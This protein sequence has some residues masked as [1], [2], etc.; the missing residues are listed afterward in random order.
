[1]LAVYAQMAERARDLAASIRAGG[2]SHRPPIF[3]N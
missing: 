1:M 3:T 2:E